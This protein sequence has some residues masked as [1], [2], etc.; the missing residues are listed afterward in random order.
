M[1]LLAFRHDGMSDAASEPG[2]TRYLV[3]V[4][5]LAK[6]CMIQDAFVRTIGNIADKHGW[7][8]C[9]MI[10]SDGQS[11][12]PPQ[13]LVTHPFPLSHNFMVACIHHSLVKEK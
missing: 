11:G 4:Q 12:Y 5:E 13:R 3:R 9:T 8:S 1:G 2:R 7:V 6:E 10:G